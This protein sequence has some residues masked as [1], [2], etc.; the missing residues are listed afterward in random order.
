MS[1]CLIPAWI[2]RFLCA[3]LPALAA[4]SP[5]AGEAVA[6]R[7]DGAER[8]Y[9]LYVPASYSDA[10]PAPLLLVLHGR[11]SSGVRMA[12]LTEFNARADEHGFIV[13]YPDGLDQAWNY[14]HDIPGYREG[15]NDSDFLLE[16]VAALSGRYAVD[17]HRVYVAGISNGGFMAQRLACYAPG[18]FAAFASV[19]A[20]GFAAMPAACRTTAPVS[21]LYIHGTADRKVPWHGLGVEDADGKRQLVAMSI[22]D[23]L[24]FWSRRNRC[25]PQVR[26]RTLPAA[27]G[28]PGTSVQFLTA[29]ECENDVEVSLYAV[30][31][32]G[33]NW[34]G[35]R[36]VIP[37]RIAGR[38]NMDI[39][40]SDVIWSFFARNPGK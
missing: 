8:S 27:G 18:K 39:H 10:T 19:A 16:I 26:V 21:A 40:A 15:P 23:T 2:P 31:G 33:H 5:A 11:S 4:V 22:T 7:H 14:V 13:A 25:G 35:S 34:P 3:L 6:L 36:G 30:T 17:G 38:V 24:K 20:G 12:R 37:P 32:G 1:R 29:S 9:Q 28:S